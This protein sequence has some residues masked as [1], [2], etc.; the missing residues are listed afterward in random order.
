MLSAAYIRVSSRGQHFDLQHHAIDAQAKLRGD[1]PQ[2]FEEKRSG[3]QL[4]RPQLDQLRLAVKSGQVKRL[5]VFR[6]DRL[7]R[8]GIRDTF[9]LVEELRAHGCELITCS[10][11]FDLSGPLA[12]PL[13]AL[14]AWAARMENHARRER[15]AAARER[16]EAK[17]GEWGRPRRMTAAQLAKARA[18]RGEEPPK[19][20]RAISVALKLPLATLARA[21]KRGV[22]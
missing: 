16:V 18:M 9:E 14:M 8:S 19:S 6:L 7:T 10:D 22:P 15:Q 1:S 3:S 20:L 17:G 13:I 5:Y 2:L 4:A 12:E 21:L 11:G